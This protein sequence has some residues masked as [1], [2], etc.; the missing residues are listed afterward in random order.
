MDAKERKQRW[1]NNN[2]EKVRKAWTAWRLR[3][4]ASRNRYFKEYKKLHLEK[5]NA[6]VKLQQAVRSGKIKRLPCKVCQKI[7][8]QAHHPDYS[9]PLKVIWLCKKHHT[10]IHFTPPA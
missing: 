1:A 8:S 6:R 9:K 5:A 7:P 10:E 2:R 4:K 3:N